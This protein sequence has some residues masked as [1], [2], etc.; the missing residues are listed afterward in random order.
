MSLTTDLGL[1]KKCYKLEDKHRI[2]KKNL[3]FKQSCYMKLQSRVWEILIDY[4][5]S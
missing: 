5:H 1:L 2:C 3:T 4:K